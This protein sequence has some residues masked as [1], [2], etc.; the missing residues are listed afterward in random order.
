MNLAVNEDFIVSSFDLEGCVS[1]D[2]PV[3]T[4]RYTDISQET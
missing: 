4:G 2:G 3:V 1:F